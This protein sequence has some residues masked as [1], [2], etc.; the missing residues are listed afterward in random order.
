MSETIATCMMCGVR[1]R[2]PRGIPVL[3]AAAAAEGAARAL[4][5]RSGLI[6]PYPVR[7]ASYFSAAELLRARRFR[8]PQMALGLAASGVELAV[9][10]RWRGGRVALAASGV[11]LRVL[12]RGRAGRLRPASEA[13]A[14]TAATTAAALPLRAVARRRGVRV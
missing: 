13:A 3:A 10:M 6:A 12:M 7:A 8:Y 1:R 9:L 5:P 14:L 2:L 4:R 11:D